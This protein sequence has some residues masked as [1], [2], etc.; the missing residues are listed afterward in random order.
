MSTSTFP[1][2]NTS[3]IQ[4]SQTQSSI[5]QNSTH[6]S[7]IGQELQSIFASFSLF[8]SK[9]VSKSSF[10][11][12]TNY[13]MTFNTKTT[14]TTSE[15]FE[16]EKIEDFFNDGDEKFDAT[17]CFCIPVR[18]NRRQFTKTEKTTAEKFLSI[19]KN[20]D[21]QP[22]HTEFETYVV[23]DESKDE[24]EN[25]TT[26]FEKMLYANDTAKD[27]EERL[28]E[29]EGP[30]E[31]KFVDHNPEHQTPITNQREFNPKRSHVMQTEEYMQKVEKNQHFEK[32]T[33]PNKTV[34]YRKN[35]VAFNFLIG[36]GLLKENGGSKTPSKSSKLD[37]RRSATK[38]L[39]GIVE[40]EESTF[41]EVID[42]N[43]NVITGEQ[44][45]RQMKHSDAVESMSSR[46]KSVYYRANQVFD[47]IKGR[48]SKSQGLRSAQNSQ[49]SVT[50][51]TLAN[52]KKM[53]NSGVRQSNQ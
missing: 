24:T 29:D 22:K 28:E 16:E 35:T 17:L 43:R 44:F 18:L 1:N 9:Q 11:K 30:K 45:E 26:L 5:N 34:Y 31:S 4:K 37:Q 20:S 6:H 49:V 32:L 51:D 36:T 47:F 15:T 41:Q 50:N 39:L 38:S 40:E 14:P 48:T 52:I 21:D 19:Y 27:T 12:P 13:K 7:S 33:N 25:S 42:Q 8:G 10:G 53:K 3:Q 2:K 46:K 23:E